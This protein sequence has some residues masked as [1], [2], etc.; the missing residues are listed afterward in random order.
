MNSCKFCNVDFEKKRGHLVGTTKSAG[1]AVS[2]SG[3]R[4]RNSTG[5]LVYKQPNTAKSDHEASGKPTGERS[6]CR[7]G[8]SGG[9][10][11]STT[12]MNRYGIG[13]SGGVYGG[14]QSNLLFKDDVELPEEW[15]TSTE[16]VNIGNYLL[17]NLN[18]AA[19]NI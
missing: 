5:Y 4:P 18:C 15:D 13:L 1:Y 19:K 6:G 8:K 3:G 9:R 16:T 10:P 17:C 14:T 12:K 7:V 2:T 11:T